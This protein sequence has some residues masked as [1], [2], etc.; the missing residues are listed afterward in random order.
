M[1][2]QIHCFE[3]PAG[4]FTTRFPKIFK[5]EAV[6]AETKEPTGAGDGAFPLLEACRVA[7]EMLG[8]FR[9]GSGGRIVGACREPAL[10]Q[11]HLVPPRRCAPAAPLS[12][13]GAARFAQIAAG[14]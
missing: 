5:A 6:H 1:E 8:A 12:H 13:A 3:T 4:S 2:I 11:P 7:P 10:T 14:P 9:H